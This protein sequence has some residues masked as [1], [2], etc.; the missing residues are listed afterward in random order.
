MASGVEAEKPR[1][2]EVGM[3]AR[4]A[5]APAPSGAVGENTGGEGANG[6]GLEVGADPVAREGLV[7]AAGLDRG[8]L[9]EKLGPASP[10]GGAVGALKTVEVSPGATAARPAGAE[11]KVE[12][13]EA[14]GVAGEAA[15]L[16]AIGVRDSSALNSFS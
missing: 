2:L 8:L 9:G 5:A 6:G 4:V 12:V 3:V 7:E 16:A 10:G 1:P 11:K 15:K 13:A 14:D